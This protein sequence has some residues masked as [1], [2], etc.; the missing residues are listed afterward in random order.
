MEPEM[1]PNLPKTNDFQQEFV[2]LEDSKKWPCLMIEC[3]DDTMLHN[4]II[5]HFETTNM[6]L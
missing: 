5:K 2:T 6:G 4:K 3:M 1:F